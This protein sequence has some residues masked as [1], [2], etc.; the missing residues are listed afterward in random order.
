MVYNMTTEVS[1]MFEV[2]EN[3][4][5]DINNPNKF[6]LD[7][8]EKDVWSFLVCSRVPSDIY[9]ITWRKSD[10][11]T[12]PNILGTLKLPGDVEDWELLNINENLPQ[13]ELVA[14]KLDNGGFI[15]SI[16]N[17]TDVMIEIGDSLDNQVQAILLYNNSTNYMLAYSMLSTPIA[18][19]NYIR[20]PYNGAICGANICSKMVNTTQEN[21]DMNNLLEENAK[22]KALLDEIDDYV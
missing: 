15:I 5:W 21:I 18:T 19:Q 14:K 13:I 4:W 3:F 1:M 20:I 16:N 7:N 9:E 2:N 12:D 10:G 22:L 6:T 8:I 11:V 17:T